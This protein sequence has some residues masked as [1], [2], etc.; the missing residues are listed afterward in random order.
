VARIDD[1]PDQPNALNVRHRPVLQKQD[2]ITDLD[3]VSHR[4]PF[5]VLTPFVRL[6]QPQDDVAAALGGAAVA[7]GP[8]S[9][10]IVEPTGS[11]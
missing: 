6:R 9:L 11:E 4:L 8:V 3:L 2:I 5:L 10:N 7:S 1:L